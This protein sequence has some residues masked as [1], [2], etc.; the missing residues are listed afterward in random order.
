[1]TLFYACRESHLLVDD[2]HWDLT[3]TDAALSSSSHQIRQIFSII[4]LTCFPSKASALCVSHGQLYVASSRVG[5]LS[6]LCV[7]T[8]EGLT[9]NIEHPMTLR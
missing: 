7:F 4:L 3:L 6:N 9:K 2:N 8:P 1:M 5:K